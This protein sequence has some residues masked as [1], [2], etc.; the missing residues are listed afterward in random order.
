MFV[1]SSPTFGRNDAWRNRLL[2]TKVL[3]ASRDSADSITRPLLVASTLPARRERDHK[4]ANDIEIP[5]ERLL[6]ELVGE[7]APC[8]HL[9]V[10]RLVLDA[11]EH[12]GQW[13][14]LSVEHRHTAMVADQVQI[15]KDRSMLEDLQWSS[16][17]IDRSCRGERRL[18]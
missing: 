13:S 9:A 17:S 12:L 18:P 5:T 11:G 6:G 1:N 2:L 16:T 3:R 4:K 10:G 8:G 7:V 15:R 14:A